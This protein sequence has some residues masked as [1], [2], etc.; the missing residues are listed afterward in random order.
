MARRTRLRLERPDNQDKNSA[1]S[2]CLSRHP[3]ALLARQRSAAYE[4]IFIRV[5]GRGFHRRPRRRPST[6]LSVLE[7]SATRGPP[8]Q[9]PSLR[10]CSAWC[11]SGEISRP[12]G[13]V[14][15]G[16]KDVRRNAIRSALRRACRD[17]RR[18]PDLDSLDQWLNSQANAS[19]CQL[20]LDCLRFFGAFSSAASRAPSV[21]RTQNFVR[22]WAPGVTS[23]PLG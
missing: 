19:L 20:M 2:R 21:H 14:L 18:R 6:H 7:R 3:S 11:P 22:H 4:G 13:P 23:E 12:R 16:S 10:S 8:P 9:C 5:P 1:G 15:H 17:S